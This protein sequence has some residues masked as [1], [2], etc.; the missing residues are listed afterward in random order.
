MTR[1][2]H[3][4]ARA[5]RRSTGPEGTALSGTRVRYN[6]PILISN[7]VSGAFWLVLLAVLGPWALSLIGAAYV[8]AGSLFLAA[9]YGRRP[10]RSQEL[11]AWAVPWLAA[12]AVWAFIGIRISFENTPSQYLFALYLG[13]VIGTPCYVAWQALALAVRHFLAWRSGTSLQGQ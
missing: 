10:A 9:V 6:K 11:L 5:P 8:V 3:G 7:L 13:F 1:P 4:P 12:V 2:A